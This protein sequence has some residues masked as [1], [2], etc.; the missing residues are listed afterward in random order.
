MLHRLRLFEESPQRRERNHTTDECKTSLLQGW[1]RHWRQPKVVRLDLDEA[2]MSNRMLVMLEALQQN[3]QVTAAESPKHL[4]VQGV[5]A[6]VIQRKATLYALDEG[7]RFSYC[8]EHDTHRSSCCLDT[9]QKPLKESHSAW[10]RKFG[11]SQTCV[12]ERL[13]NEQI[14]CNS[15][16]DPESDERRC[17][18]KMF[19][20]SRTSP[21]N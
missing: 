6:Q 5:V 19:T 9:N 8:K 3:V 7:R 2:H 4:G 21:V 14:V 18:G 17:S 12:A 1:M 13:L 15:T 11:M 16:A 10:T 20:P